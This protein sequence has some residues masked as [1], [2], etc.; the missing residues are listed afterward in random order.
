MPP[1]PPKQP[2]LPKNAQAFRERYGPWVLV[3]GASEGLGA[4]FA[5]ALAARKLNVA[6]VARRQPLLESLAQALAAEH[7][8][9]TRVIAADLAADRAA[10][11]LADVCD[12]LDLGLLIYN[13]A[14]SVIGPFLD[15]E[16][17]R[18]LQEINVNCR[19]PMHLT[20]R[21]GRR[22]IER[23]RGGVVLMSSL[24]GLQ[25]SPLVANY[26][27]TKAYNLVLAEGLWDEWRAQGVHVLAS[28]AGSTRTP[29]FEKSLP[30]AAA[31][32]PGQ[33]MD[34]AA[35]AELTLAALGR[36]PSFIPGRGNRLASLFLHRLM[37]RR[38]AVRIMGRSMRGLYKV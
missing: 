16:A 34:P 18:H 13:A 9:E 1:C 21:L 11:D 19:T 14:F 24:A 38:V 23:G 5:H 8:V 36:G 29:N 32:P 30:D 25:G 20:H 12:S 22:F 4:A 6:L 2:A 28:C 15:A 26:G 3:A 7:G 37:P 17:E 33:I 35:V 10:A 31:G 27:A